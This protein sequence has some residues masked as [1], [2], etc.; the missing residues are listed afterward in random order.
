MLTLDPTINIGNILTASILLIGFVGA[1]I[2][3]QKRLA[4]IEERL[5]LMY[6][7]WTRHIVYSKGSGEKDIS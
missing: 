2:Q 5:T 7:W 4:K 6:S 1:H 3:N